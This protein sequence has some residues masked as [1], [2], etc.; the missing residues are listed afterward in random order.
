MACSEKVLQ[1]LSKPDQAALMKHTTMRRLLAFLDTQSTV[2]FKQLKLEAQKH[3]AV[4][5]QQDA[6]SCTV[7][8]DRLLQLQ[9]SSTEA[10]SLQFLTPAPAPT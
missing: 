9:I 1:Q 10:P 2:D 4:F 3:G 7:Q 8:V 6:T 5:I